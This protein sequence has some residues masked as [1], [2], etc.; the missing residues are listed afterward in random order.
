ME[1]KM[2]PSVI[3]ELILEFLRYQCISLSQGIRHLGSCRIVRINLVNPYSTAIVEK[4]FKGVHSFKG[5][6]KG[7]VQGIILRVIEGDT[8]SLDYS[9]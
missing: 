9:L 1:T 7:I 6:I 8:W 3:Q 4:P 5:L 2:E